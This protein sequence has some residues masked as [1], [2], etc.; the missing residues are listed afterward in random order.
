VTR[1][2]G[3]LVLAIAGLFAG[4]I[5]AESMLWLAGV[6]YPSFQ[7][8][9][10]VLGWTLRP[11]ARGYW[12]Q[13]GGSLV[14][15]NNEGLH[16]DR[17]YTI[18]KPPNTFRIAVVGNSYT[19]AVQ[20]PAD[21]NYC[22]RLSSELEACPRLAGRRIEVL[23]FG[24]GAYSTGQELLKLRTHVWAYSPDLVILA[25]M[26]STDLRLNDRA[27]ADPASKR[28]IRPY[29][30]HNNGRIELDNSFRQDSSAVPYHIMF[31]RLEY[32]AVDHS[33]IFEVIQQVRNHRNQVA[34]PHVE[35]EELGLDDAIYRPPHTPEWQEAWRLSEDLIVEMYH[36]VSSHHAKFLVVVLT[37]GI[38][39]YP[40]ASVRQ[41]FM[42][43]LGVT[44]L[45]YAD[46]RLRTLGAR[47]GIDVL[48][49]TPEFQRYADQTH[50]VLH[51]FAE[52]HN[53]GSGHWNAEGHRLAAA[54]LAREI[55]R[56]TVEASPQ[57][58]SERVAFSNAHVSRQ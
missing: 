18:S 3:K 52:T 40:D 41:Q 57:I 8:W 7:R 32:W 39:V 28:P 23:N 53:L 4:V 54:L 1:F 26:P 58:D 6:E 16:D 14:L 37:N 22:G 20:V 36:E 27:L 13:E 11:G 19:E 48:P 9:D 50:T 17:D 33:R 55:C 35:G 46:D 47:E 2:I 45:S 42:Q 56:L 44:T 10:A 29:F 5:A 34:A 49:L 12:R 43:H 25:F 30:L 24:V 31:R 21:K 51:G 15:I 38:Q